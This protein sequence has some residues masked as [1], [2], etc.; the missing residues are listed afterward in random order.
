MSVPPVRP[1][2]AG[3]GKTAGA[4]LKGNVRRQIGFV[5]A[6]QSLVPAMM[7]AVF[8]LALA[9]Y[10]IRAGLDERT[11]R[12]V[13]TGLFWVLCAGLISAY[14]PFLEPTIRFL[15][16]HPSLAAVLVALYALVYGQVGASYGV[17]SLFWSELG[18]T[19]FFAGHGA[20]LVV[21]LLLTSV[22][23]VD[24][25]MDSRLDQID[26][27]FNEGGYRELR[28]FLRWPWLADQI[29]LAPA[30]ALRV[31]LRRD[32]LGRVGGHANLNTN[33]LRAFTAVMG[34]PLILLL[35]V[36]AVLPGFF[37]ALPRSVPTRIDASL[38][39]GKSL[40]YAPG[41]EGS[42]SG[43]VVA[44]TPSN[45][46]VPPDLNV[47]NPEDLEQGLDPTRDVRAWGFGL[48]LWGA[49]VL[50]GSL[51][52]A[53]LVWV[54]EQAHRF[55]ARR[56][57][58][59]SHWEVSALLRILALNEDLIRGQE[60]LIDARERQLRA[61][62]D[63]GATPPRVTEGF[64]R[65]LRAQR[66]RL[67]ADRE[68]WRGELNGRAI[69][70]HTRWGVP[71]A[72]RQEQEA[73]LAGREELFDFA[74][75][76]QDEMIELLG[77]AVGEE[78]PPGDAGLAWI[79]AE[80]AARHVGRTRDDLRAARRRLWT[81]RT[82]LS[83]YV[84]LG[85]VVLFYLV[86]VAFYEIV[87]PAYAI[88][89]LLW[90]LILLFAPIPGLFYTGKV[91]LPGDGVQ[92]GVRFLLGLFL[93]LL[94]VGSSA[95]RYK[96][97]FPHLD[98]A[99]PRGYWDSRPLVQLDDAM[100]AYNA[101]PRPQPFDP[102][103]Q[104]PE[105]CSG[106]PALVPNLE[107]LDAWRHRVGRDRAGGNRDELP[108][109]AVVAVSG[110]GIRSAFWTAY[111]L[112]ALEDEYA[113]RVAPATDPGPVPRSFRDHVRLIAGASG[114][115]V[116]AAYYV[117]SS[118]KVSGPLV[119]DKAADSPTIPW[120]TVED[121]AVAHFRKRMPSDSLTMP[122]SYM[123]L[124]E[125]LWAL[126]P[127][128]PWYPLFSPA[129]SGPIDRGRVLDESWG[130]L[131]RILV[132]NLRGL[133]RTG[134]IPSLVFSPMLIEDGR[135]L[136]ISNLD[137]A[138]AARID[139]S[140]IRYDDSTAVPNPHP[141]SVSAFE[142]FR[143][144]PCASDFRLS[145]A[146]RMSASFPFI[147]PAVALSTNPPRRVV[148]AGYYDNYGVQV[149]A[150]W[151]YEH[152]QWLMDNTSGVALVRI[153]DF[154]GQRD[155]LEIARAKAPG[156]WEILR[157]GVEY[158]ASPVEAV[159]E[160]RYSSSSFRN[161]GEIVYLSALFAAK[162]GPG[163]FTMVPFENSEEV[164]LSWAIT[165]RERAQLR[166]SI[167]G[168]NV[169]RD[170]EKKRQRTAT[171]THID[172]VIEGLVKPSSRPQVLKEGE[173]DPM[174]EAERLMNYRRVRQLMDWWFR[175]AVRAPQRVD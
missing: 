88:Y 39:L 141:Y 143:L 76:R 93:L 13:H 150:A 56:F 133:E 156:F 138:F 78:P 135:R 71:A 48:L 167:I 28:P 108:K 44:D 97:R 173:E 172:Q 152:R 166:R 169:E 54:A 8:F 159:L 83:A 118:P 58:S 161:D 14:E 90:F 142:F 41:R 144:F 157:R 134:Q 65:A 69:E 164:A 67:A 110:G 59:V 40:L 100:A 80:Q 21:A 37:T 165:H 87:S 125:P 30:L 102:R 163:F 3:P 79:R 122:A 158:V 96:L 10:P 20:A 154:Q 23:H 109:L 43:F 94:L 19:R 170:F 123:V 111:V 113:R 66:E 25:G 15:F 32:R 47:K 106:G 146:V 124:R 136:L 81:G 98:A 132:L 74:I 86:L 29:V 120:P 171:A 46:V 7:F 49:G 91:T 45:A 4:A 2:G 162:K 101:D 153:R 62:E 139:G 38:V 155:R 34:Y 64:Q 107:A 145:T 36:P 92:V 130:T 63:A 73:R 55:L 22:F 128:D 16:K 5:E 68:E 77:E 11:V 168:A 160:A 9:A 119:K 57:W 53:A 26:H 103:F 52:F 82:K 50:I 72:R 117:A 140:M 116:G 31:F 148:D 137:M 85:I 151:I 70:F 131:N 95:N 112:S 126:F 147:S 51:T 121:V 115:M 60:A 27:Y 33:K 84:F 99:N 89:V 12:W 24:V 6:A 129:R 104:V 127:V 149:A 105:A 35:L 114:G 17:S 61:R 1:G 174:R 75:A 175:S 18:N 42:A